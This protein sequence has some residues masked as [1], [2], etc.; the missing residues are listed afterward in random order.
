MKTPT[1]RVTRKNRELTHKKRDTAHG[2]YIRS[3]GICAAAGF[4]STACNGDIQSC[5]VKLGEL[6]GLGRKPG[7]REKGK[8]LSEVGKHEIPMCQ[9]HHDLQGN[10]GERRFWGDRLE[11]VKSLANALW[12]FTKDLKQG[13]IHVARFI[14]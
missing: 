5:H 11:D 1:Q 8:E 9:A 6:A 7:D 4:H 12:Y 3:I 14:R 13:K 10:M 2:A